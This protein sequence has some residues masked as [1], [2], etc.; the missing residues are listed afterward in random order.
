MIKVFVKK[1]VWADGFQHKTDPNVVAQVTAELEEQNILTAHNLVEDSR[2]EDAP[3]HGEFEWNDEIAAEKYREEQARGLIRHLRVV[4]ENSEPKRVYCN[5][6]RVSPEY[7][8]IERAVKREDTRMQLLRNA[9]RELEAYRSK[10]AELS[11]LA[12]VNAAI[13]EFLEDMRVAQ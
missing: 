1:Y 6:V 4:T 10:Y 7:T 9:M 13:D 2:P 11:E 3:L 8:L 12:K 5:L